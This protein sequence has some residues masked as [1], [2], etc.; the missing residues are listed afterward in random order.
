MVRKIDIKCSQFGKQARSQHEL[1]SETAD[2]LWKGNKF[3]RAKW[4]LRSDD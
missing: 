4:I 2:K 1:R 3:R